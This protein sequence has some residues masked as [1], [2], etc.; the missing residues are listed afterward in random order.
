MKRFNDFLEND[1]YS[2]K[3]Y[4]GPELDN[5]LV[6]DFYKDV[7]ITNEKGDLKSESDYISLEKRNRLAESVFDDDTIP[8]PKYLSENSDGTL[9]IILEDS[10]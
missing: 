4:I 3:I 8:A 5:Q 1:D 6:F 10:F 2:S 9:R 7:E